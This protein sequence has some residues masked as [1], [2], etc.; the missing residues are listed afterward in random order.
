MDLLA[1]ISSGSNPNIL[2][3]AK[4]KVVLPI[5]AVPVKNTHPVYGVFVK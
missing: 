5:P 2:V 4:A 1:F 3:D